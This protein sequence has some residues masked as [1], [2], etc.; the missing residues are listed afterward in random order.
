MYKFTEKSVDF[1][2]P[3]NMLLDENNLYV[4]YSRINAHALPT[5][6]IQ[7]VEFYEEKIQKKTGNVIT[8]YL[9]G[10]PE[11]TSET[12]TSFA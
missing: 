5:Q 9:N 2:A 6:E 1:N 7:S 10:S 12:Y 11:I 3:I 8:G 4:S